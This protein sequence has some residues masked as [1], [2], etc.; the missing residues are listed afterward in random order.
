MTITLVL[1]FGFVLWLGLYMINRDARNSRLLLMGLALLIYAGGLAAAVL[2]PYSPAAG[3]TRALSNVRDLAFY[4]PLLFWQGALLHF[5][6]EDV[7]LRK[8]SITIWKY[9]LV[10]IILFCSGWLFFAAE[11]AG[12]Q[13]LHTV[14]TLI[15]SL[16]FVACF[17]FT[18]GSF[19]KKRMAVS[20]FLL[21][22]TTILFIGCTVGVV[23]VTPAGWYNGIMLV[24]SIS[25]FVL[26][27]TITRSEITEQG[28]AWL[29]D[30]FRSLDYS[31]F[32]ALLFSG[33][34]AIA[35][36][37]SNR[38]SFSMM[39]LLVTLISFSIVTQVFFYQIRTVLDNFAFMMFP[40][41]REESSQIRL[42]D[43]VRIRVDET[44]AP[45]M[46]DD[47]SLFRFTR[48]A[49]SSLGDLQR[50]A[51]SPLTQLQLIERR[52]SERGVQDDVLERAI[53]LK[54]VLT[55]GIMQLKP[56]QDEAFGTT[57]EWRHYN[58]LYFPYVVGIKPYSRRDGHELL[59]ATAQEAL[60]WFRTFVPERTCYNWQ[61]AAA[62]LVA[63]RLKEKSSP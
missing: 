62:R 54:A 7:P 12:Y 3:V 58:S 55:E 24:G 34:V 39:I 40:K 32:F 2:L 44:A 51:S 60:E 11:H 61:N 9:G 5:L 4:L 19:L 31:V 13:V 38:N 25:L 21:T 41:L 10:P 27:V 8:P 56:R 48:R 22:V 47:E 15:A 29:P 23:S 36:L 37:W 57:D 52:L 50:L 18:I 49:L 46:I 1:C 30:F 45:E 6:P 43:S 20:Q 42:A 35:I 26:S 59:D 33:Q 63:L 17:V 53:E 28:E 16:S 14:L